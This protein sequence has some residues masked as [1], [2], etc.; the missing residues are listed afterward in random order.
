MRVTINLA[1][2]SGPRELVEVLSAADAVKPER[3]SVLD[4]LDMLT[5]V[6]QGALTM[7]L[8][9]LESIIHRGVCRLLPIEEAP[10]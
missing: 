10:G 2:G 3:N 7:A 5:A 8:T 9:G 1:K 4:P 6:V